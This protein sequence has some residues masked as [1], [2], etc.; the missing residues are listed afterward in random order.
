VN[1]G[2]VMDWSKYFG[3]NAGLPA[4]SQP[5]QSLRAFTTG[6]PTVDAECVE[7]QGDVWRID[8][9]RQGLFARL[10]KRPQSVRLF[11]LVNPGVEECL[12]VYRA[13]LRTDGP[14]IRAYLEMWC[15]FAG[16]E[17]FSK[18]VGFNQVASGTTD[19]TTYET[20][21]L[22]RKGEAPELLRLNIAVMGSGTILVREVEIL[23]ASGEGGIR[24]RG[25]V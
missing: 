4:L 7:V 5:M 25:E 11:E 3:A 16:R 23:C 13:Q 18:G 22:L 14:I 2:T 17:Y 8:V 20:P 24:T 12:L 10:F 15:R 9:E 6:D 1:G 21:F 19:W